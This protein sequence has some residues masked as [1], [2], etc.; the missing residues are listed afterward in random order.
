MSHLHHRQWSQLRHHQ[1]VHP[2]PQQKGH[3]QCHRILRQAV[4]LTGPPIHHQR[5]L[6]H[7]LVFGHH[8]IPLYLPQLDH[9]QFR[10][11][12]RLKCH[13]DRHQNLRH[14]IRRLLQRGILLH[15]RVMIHL[16]IQLLNQ[17]MVHLHIP[18]QLHQL[19]HH[20]IRHKYHQ[21]NHLEVHR[22]CQQ[23]LH[24]LIRQ[25]L[26]PVFIAISHHH[27]PLKHLVAG[28]PTTPLHYSPT[29][30]PRKQHRF[31]QLYHQIIHRD[32]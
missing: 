5:T 14:Q 26:R 32:S 9:P 3:Q 6:L 27:T 7:N 15:C 29:N 28:L 25:S 24:L 13:Q 18:R 12:L 17:A 20:W 31:H 23:K 16:R 30:R 8:Q 10:V 22:Q 21:R 2:G 1:A 4:H 19:H 11:W